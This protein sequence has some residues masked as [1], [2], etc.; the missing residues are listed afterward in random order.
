MP[1][2][3]FLDS[4]VMMDPVDLMCIQ[5]WRTIKLSTSVFPRGS[6]KTLFI[7][8]SQDFWVQM[9]MPSLDPKRG[10]SVARSGASPPSK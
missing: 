10:E 3:D 9:Q 8:I 6:L 1:Q 2:A 7:G 5:V 4:Q